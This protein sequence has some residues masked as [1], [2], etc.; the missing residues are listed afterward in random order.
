MV[1]SAGISHPANVVIADVQTNE[2]IA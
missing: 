1:D 2:I